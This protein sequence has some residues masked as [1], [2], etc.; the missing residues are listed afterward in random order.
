MSDMEE[1]AKRSSEII[2]QATKRGVEALEEAVATFQRNVM[3][4]IGVD[5]SGDSNDSR[6]NSDLDT[7]FVLSTMLSIQD[8]VRWCDKAKS[9]LHQYHS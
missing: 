3:V 5:E 9:I 2:E 6:A 7:N 4:R 1:S 8:I